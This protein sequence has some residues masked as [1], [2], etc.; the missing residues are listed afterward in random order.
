VDLYGPK[1]ILWDSD[2][3]IDNYG[4]GVI[5]ISLPASPHWPALDEHRREEIANDF[6]PR[7]LMYRLK[8]YAKVRES[9][10]DVSQFTVATRRLAC[11]LAACFPGD[12]GLV[13]DTILLLRPQDEEIRAQRFLDVAYI[14][15]EILWGEIHS[16]EHKQVSVSKLA[17]DANALL[18]SRGE[19]REY[20]AEEVGWKLKHLNIPK[21]TDTSGRQV[22]LDHDTSRRVHR[23]A[24]TYDLP[25]SQHVRD[26]CSDCA[27]S[28]SPVAK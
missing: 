10:V 27:A 6:Q 21:H 11:A 7:L 13:R 24:Q 8:N 23:L 22:L 1:A 9:R 12:P 14:L 4:E 25:R 19:F 5:Q 3:A 28:E 26:G 20:S 18:L 17:K 15:V 2:A 16:R